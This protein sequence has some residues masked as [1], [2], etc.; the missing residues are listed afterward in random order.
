MMPSATAISSGPSGA[1]PLV[2]GMAPARDDRALLMSALNVT[3]DSFSDGGHYFDPDTA[4]ARARDMIAEG[5]DILDIGGE[6][7]RPGSAEISAEEELARLGPVLE[8]VIPECGVP[9][10]IDTYKGATAQAA[11]KAGAA[12]VNDVWGFTR[13]PSIIKVTAEHGAAGIIGHWEPDL[14]KEP[15]DEIIP[16][17]K[18]FFSAQVEKSL[19]AGIAEDRITLDPGIGFGKTPAQNLVILHRL[20]E[21]CALGF[22]VLV[23]ASRKRFIGEVT[24]R[25]PLERLAGTVSA[26]LMAVAN[27]AAAIRAHDV[28]THHDAMRVMHAI[29]TQTMPAE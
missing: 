29:Q 2:G 23:G 28:A 25:E 24:G 10:S 1:K 19:A 14:V 5:A 12:I 15:D 7:T 18:A 13:D 20:P 16:R 22:P 8:A 3:P 11:L 4:I 27:G 17:M 6:S 26:H 21:I 9:V